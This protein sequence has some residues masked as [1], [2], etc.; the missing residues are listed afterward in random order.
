MGNIVLLTGEPRIGKTTP[1]KKLIEIIGD[2]NCTGFYTE[3]IRGE[4]DRIG[5]D[6]VSIDGKRTRIADVNLHSNI[7]VGRYGIDIEAFENFAFQA[8]DISSWSGK[9]TIIDEIG[10]I[11]LQST[12]F[13]QEIS[14]V[15]TSSHCV[16]GTIFYDKHPDI[17]EIKKTPGIR[18]YHMTKENRDT[19]LED[20]FNKIQVI[21]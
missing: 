1:L 6:C 18:M 12:K 5:F 17:D 7:R 21:I 2:A 9:V 4:L 11:Q 8:I 10:P 20:I 3:E 19:I 15:L 14:S 16:I 13:K